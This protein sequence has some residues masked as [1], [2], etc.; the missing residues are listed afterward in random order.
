ME[1]EIKINFEDFTCSV[2][3]TNFPI[4]HIKHLSDMPKAI[5]GQLAN[6]AMSLGMPETLK[7]K[8]I[9][10]ALDG[11]VTRQGICQAIE[12]RCRD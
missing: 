10:E 8:L 7:E 5:A 12:P 1:Q 3:I 4:E 6:V 11:N 9:K 2:V